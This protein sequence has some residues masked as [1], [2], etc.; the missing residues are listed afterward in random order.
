VAEGSWWERHFGKGRLPAE[1]EAIADSGPAVVAARVNVSQ[2]GSYKIPGKSTSAEAK[3]LAGY[4]VVLPDRVVA[5]IGNTKVVDVPLGR[6]EGQRGPGVIS[7]DAHGVLFEIDVGQARPADSS[8]QA[9]F[10][11]K[12][13]FSDDA[14]AMMRA[15]SVSVAVDGDALPRLLGSHRR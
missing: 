1:L 14:L 15:R 4:L 6:P 12:H 3:L 2:R 9:R 8:G 11:F 13:H 5:T 10:L 7:I